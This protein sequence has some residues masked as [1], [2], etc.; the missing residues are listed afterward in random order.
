MNQISTKVLEEL[1]SYLTEVEKDLSQ[2]TTTEGAFTRHRKLPFRDLV[3]F[4]LSLLKKVFKVNSTLFLAAKLVPHHPLNQPL[5]KPERNSMTPSM[6]P[7]FIK[8][9]PLLRLMPCLKNSKAT[10]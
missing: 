7:F 3:C 4:Q 9:C 5:A 6:N 10:A 8:L 1:S 2:F